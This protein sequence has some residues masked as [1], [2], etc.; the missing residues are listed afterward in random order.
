MKAEIKTITPQIAE[1]ML[2]KNPSNRHI[3]KVNLH[4]LEEIYL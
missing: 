3:R 2:G 4:N 1:E